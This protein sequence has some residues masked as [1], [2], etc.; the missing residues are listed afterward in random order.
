MPREKGYCEEGDLLLGE[1]PISSALSVHKFI[2]DTADEI[3]IRISRIYVTPIQLNQLERIGRLVLRLANARLASGRILMAQGQA[4]QDDS[5][6]AYAMHLINEAEATLDSIESGRLSLEGAAFAAGLQTIA[7]PT[8]KN[9]DSES[10]V[11]AF[12]DEF[13][14]GKPRSPLPNTPIWRPGV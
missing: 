14:G 2:T 13:L 6:H 4:S 5:L 12:Y 3:D 7:G 11:D 8:I 10:G 9:R 1:M